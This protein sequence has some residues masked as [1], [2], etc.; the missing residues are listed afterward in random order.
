MTAALAVTT[1]A[2]TTITAADGSQLAEIGDEW[3][4]RGESTGGAWVR[5]PVGVLAGYA[6]YAAV[7]AP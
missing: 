2:P 4:H 7:V 5:L 3:W 1:P 6:K